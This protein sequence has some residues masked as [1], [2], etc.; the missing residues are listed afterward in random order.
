MELVHSV[1]G[2]PS[3]F[4]KE[5]WTEIQFLTS[6][7]LFDF[8]YSYFLVIDKY[9]LLESTKKAVTLAE[10]KMPFVSIIKSNQLMLCREI[11]TF[12]LVNTENI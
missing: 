6:Q 7:A 4:Q 11:L 8:S 5:V 1:Q 2:N 10:T 12:I 9:L 3:A